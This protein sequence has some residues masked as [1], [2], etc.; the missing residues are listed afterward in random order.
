[1]RNWKNINKKYINE[2]YLYLSFNFLKTWNKEIKCQNKNKLGAPFQYPDSLIRF[3]IGFKAIYGPGVRQLE[4]ILHALKKYVPIPSVISF[5]QINRR[6]N[7]LGLT[8]VD[9]LD[10]SEEGQ[11]IAIDASGIKLY[12]SGQWIREKH[13]KKSPF[14]KIHVAINIKSKQ[15]VAV[16]ITEDSVG[17]NKEA[18]RLV[19][20]AREIA[21]VVK[22]LFDG[23]YD[24]YDIWNGLNARAIKPIIRLR[25][26]AIV[27]E[28]KSK[29]R[30]KAV[31]I[32]R[33]FE[34]KWP[35]EAGFGQRWQAETWFSSYKR[36]FGEF[37]T[38]VKPENVIRE[39][40]FKVEL[41]NK[42][43]K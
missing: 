26:N 12:N 14:L 39:I 33:D 32:C 21:P 6:K 36:R 42:L 41:C 31:K 17:D 15:A 13:K 29:K 8:L 2:G 20:E 25:K 11:I 28:S 43:I 7:Q 38:S 30:S 5:S 27:N 24:T 18:L 9:S 40:L 19:D 4:G 1:M 37:C 34:M 16:R 10:Q 35:K 22:G 23:A 3:L